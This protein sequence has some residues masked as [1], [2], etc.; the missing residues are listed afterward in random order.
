MHTEHVYL[1]AYY[2]QRSD[3]SSTP[4]TKLEVGNQ[5]FTDTALYQVIDFD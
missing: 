3:K 2:L 1:F 5:I 4:A